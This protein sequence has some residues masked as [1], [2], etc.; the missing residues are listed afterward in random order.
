MFLIRTGQKEASRKLWEDFH[1]IKPLFPVNTKAPHS[2]PAIAQYDAAV[3]FPHN[4]Y[5]TS[6][7]SF[8]LPYSTFPD[9]LSLPDTVWLR[10][11]NLLLL[12]SPQKILPFSA[13]L[14]SR[15]VFLSESLQLP[16]PEIVFSR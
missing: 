8:P 9:L 6:G 11:T 16:L 12:R 15:S 3:L 7:V 4:F 10:N 13:I 2:M 1:N 5:L 14:L